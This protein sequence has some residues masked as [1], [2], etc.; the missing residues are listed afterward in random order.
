[1]RGMGW[2]VSVR[3]RGGLLRSSGYA[4]ATCFCLQHQVIGRRVCGV[5]ST[6]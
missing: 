5:S 2:A 1:V 6:G 4:C 3:P